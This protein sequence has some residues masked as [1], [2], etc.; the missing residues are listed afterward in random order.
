MLST[1]V[2]FTGG[3]SNDPTYESICDDDS[4]TEVVRVTFD[5]DI[6]SYDDILTEFWNLS[7]SRATKPR[8][9]NQYK[10]AIWTCS[11][12]QRATAQASKER[13]TSTLGDTPIVTEILPFNDT[14]ETDSD[15]SKTWHD[16]PERHQRYVMKHRAAKAKRA[17]DS[18]NWI[19]DWTERG[20]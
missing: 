9:K 16:A 12:E 1:R 2:G 11:D 8:N 15:P 18:Q 10:S 3:S 4:H 19:D 7:G 6:I 17:A 13:I 14:D 20:T 5:P